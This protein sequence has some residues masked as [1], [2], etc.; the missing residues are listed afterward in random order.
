MA[1]LTSAAVS[2]L[3]RA[4]SAQRAVRSA[5]VQ[6]A[7]PLAMAISPN[8]HRLLIS[9]AQGG[10]SAAATLDAA[11]NGFA[12]WFP[13]TPIDG[14]GAAA[15]IEFVSNQ[16]AVV[17]SRGD[18]A[19]LDFGKKIAEDVPAEVQRNDAVIAAYLGGHAAQK[20]AAA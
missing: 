14:L 18:L 1:A 16:R 12:G 2:A 15:A 8:G 6:V 19:V 9:D 17:A 13:A 4:G 3:A 10:V 7:D 20:G 5:A 11:G